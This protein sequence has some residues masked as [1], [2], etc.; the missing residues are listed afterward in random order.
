MS[1]VIL[2]AARSTLRQAQ[3]IAPLRVNSAEKPVLSVAEGK[4]LRSFGFAQD[5]ISTHSASLSAGPATND[6]IFYNTDIQIFI[7]L[8]PIGIYD[9]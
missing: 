8:N 7:K 5:D 6:E 2:S 4:N 9:R 3:R 1:V